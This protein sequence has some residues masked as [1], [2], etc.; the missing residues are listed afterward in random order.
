MIQAGYVRD[1]EPRGGRVQAHAP[2]APAFEPVIARTGGTYGA[3]QGPRWAMLVAI[4]ALHGLLFAALAWLDVIHVRHKKPA[5]RLTLV[6]LQP[7]PIA[8]PPAPKQQ[9]APKQPDQPVPPPIVAPP[10]IVQAPAVVVPIATAPQPAPPPPSAPAPAASPSTEAAPITPPDASARTLGNPAP[11]YP[12][13]ARLRH[14]EGTVRLRVLITAEGRVKEIAVARSSGFDALDEAALETVRKW[15]FEPGK[16]AG[17][18]VEA[19]GFLSIPF[20]L[21]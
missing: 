13:Q 7:E 3:A 2:S 10:P 19:V 9:E 16:Q 21:T 14:W 17:V 6:E 18:P 8:P 15:R 12:M 20:R 4:L 5:P 11:K 1:V